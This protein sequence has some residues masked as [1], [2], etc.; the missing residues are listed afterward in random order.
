ML[1]RY[2]RH[3]RSSF[4]RGIYSFLLITFIMTVGTLGLH[5]TEHCSYLDAFY[6]TSMI[7]TAQGLAMTP[8]TTAG[9]I[10]TAAMSFLSVGFVV[11]ALGF[12][13][14]PFLGTLWQIGVEHVKKDLQK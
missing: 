12:F 4:K 1:T 14:G 2:H 7:A 11:A 8:V 3:Y 5:W 9:K 10:F 6:Y 13:F